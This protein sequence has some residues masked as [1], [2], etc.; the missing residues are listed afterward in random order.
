MKQVL[1]YI[2]KE[3]V[4]QPDAA[5]VEIFHDEHLVKIEVRVA[6]DDAKRVIGKDGSVI[7]ALRVLAFAITGPIDKDIEIDLVQPS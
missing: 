5:S 6:P 1:D 7:K 4:E 2:I 3:L